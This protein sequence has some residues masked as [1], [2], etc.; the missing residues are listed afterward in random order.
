MVSTANHRCGRLLHLIQRETNIFGCYGQATLFTSEQDRAKSARAARERQ[1]AQ[2]K[3]LGTSS[4]PVPDAR[5]QEWVPGRR[6]L[7]VCAVCLVWCPVR[8]AL[9]D[10]LGCPPAEEQIRLKNERVAAEKALAEK[11]DQKVGG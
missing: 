11:M 2:R 6:A 8:D 3:A 7:H 9:D 10:V 4:L 5:V 1:L